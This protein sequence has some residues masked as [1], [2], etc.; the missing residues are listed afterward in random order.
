MQPDRAFELVA[1]LVPDVLV[2]RRKSIPSSEAHPSSS[3]S[4]GG[5]AIFGSVT[6]LDVVEQLRGLLELDP[7]GRHVV[8]DAHNVRLVEV[9]GADADAEEGEEAAAVVVAVDRIKLLGSWDVVITGPG[10]P[11]RVVREVQVVD[12]GEGEGEL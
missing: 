2:F 5:A 12:E 8:V 6:P 11:E 4:L 3:S 10:W 1:T 7:E 9:G